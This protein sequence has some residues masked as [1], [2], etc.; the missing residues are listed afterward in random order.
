V[1]LAKYGGKLC[2]KSSCFNE[3]TLRK[4]VE[5][6][7]AANLTYLSKALYALEYLAQL[8]KAGAVALFK[9]GSAVQLLLPRGWQRLSIDLDIET[10]LREEEMKKRL[11]EIHNRFG[12]EYF[13]YEPR[14]S[15][16]KGPFYSY[17]IGVPSGA[18]ILLDAMM[19]TAGYKTTRTR[20]RSFFYESNVEVKTPTIDSLLG[21]KLSALGPNTIGRHLEDSRNGLEYIKHLYD[22]QSLLPHI[23]NIGGALKAYE[24]CHSLQLQIREIKLDLEESL[25][26]LDYVCRFLTLTED[27]ASEC[28]SSLG[29]GSDDVIKHFRIC[30]KGAERFPPFLTF[31]TQYTWENVRETA[32]TIAFTAGLFELIRN[33]RISPAKATAAIKSLDRQAK[34]LARNKKSVEKMLDDISTLPPQLRWHIHREEMMNRPIVLVYW[35]GRFYPERLIK[36]L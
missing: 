35:Y 26:D 28:A 5:E 29:A 10:R 33:G 15:E 27:I 2:G 11:E 6:G 31:K 19:A 21:D 1:D 24:C 7:K 12:R 22:I 8:H 36:I 32:A 30:R 9:G 34:E 4:H 3:E 18:V 14:K 20:L 23:Q 25:R 16:V 17:R 13:S